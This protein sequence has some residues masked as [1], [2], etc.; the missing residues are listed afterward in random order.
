MA[1]W[2][3]WVIC[4]VNG[5]LETGHLGPVPVREVEWLDV[6]LVDIDGNERLEHIERL[7][8]EN[9]AEFQRTTDSVRIVYCGARD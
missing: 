1:D 6:S 7:L 4:P 5:Y 9:G 8:A 3:S 2:Q